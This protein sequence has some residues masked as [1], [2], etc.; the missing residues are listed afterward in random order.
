VLVY[1]HGG[2]TDEQR[3]EMEWLKRAYD[4]WDAKYSTNL[5]AF[6]VVHPTFWLK[7]FWNVLRPLL[8]S[9]FYRKLRYFDSL[10][11]LYGIIDPSQLSLPQA[12]IEYVGLLITL[13]STSH[14]SRSLSSFLRSSSRVFSVLSIFVS[15][16]RSGV[17]SSFPVS[18]HHPRVRV[19]VCSLSLSLVIW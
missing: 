3:P 4:I 14:P 5:Q 10:R 13:V 19:F 2:M 16:P 9:Q 18:S 17:F 11:K 6:L 7:L 8:S 12:V 1:L 15:S